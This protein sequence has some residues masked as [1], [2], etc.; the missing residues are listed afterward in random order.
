MENGV[1]GF[2]LHAVSPA[3][4]LGLEEDNVIILSLKMAEM[5]VRG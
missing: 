3:V 1:V 4:E 5:T 2:T